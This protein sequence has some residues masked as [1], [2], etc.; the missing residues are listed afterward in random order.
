MSKVFLDMYGRSRKGG[1][2]V[3]RWEGQ[4]I[5]IGD[6]SLEVCERWE[7]VWISPKHPI[8]MIVIGW[9]RQIYRIQGF[10]GVQWQ[11]ASEVRKP[12][13]WV[14]WRQGRGEG[15]AG[16]NGRGK[17]GRW[18]EVGRWQS[19]KEE[20]TRTRSLC[21]WVVSMEED[22]NSLI[23]SI[24]LLLNN[25]KIGTFMPLKSRLGACCLTILILLSLV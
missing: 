18:E 16:R 9:L 19:S 1:V 11:S 15:K 12:C 3:W 22:F 25:K 20:E 2:G 7:V 8:T 13:Q 24:F 17:D 4:D 5:G 10:S 21:Y 23:L 14:E 6:G